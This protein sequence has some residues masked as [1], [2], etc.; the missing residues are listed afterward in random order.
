MKERLAASL[1]PLSQSDSA[2]GTGNNPSSSQF[3]PLRRSYCVQDTRKTK[4]EKTQTLPPKGSAT[5]GEGNRVQ[6]SY[7]E[8]H[9]EN[10]PVSGGHV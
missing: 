3:Q 5:S 4:V 8:A 6:R 7:V 2:T 9:R 1:C 10:L